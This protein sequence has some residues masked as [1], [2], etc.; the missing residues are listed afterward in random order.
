[1]Y[2]NRRSEKNNSPT[3]FRNIP[4]SSLCPHQGG[5]LYMECHVHLSLSAS[6]SGTQTWASSSLF[7]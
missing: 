6:T 5:L 1:M 2:Y 7:T 4:P 3:G